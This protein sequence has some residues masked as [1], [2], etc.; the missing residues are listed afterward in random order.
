[1]SISYQALAQKKAVYYGLYGAG[2]VLLL[3]AG[4]LWWSK[5]SVEPQRVF[6]NMLQNSLATTG[7]ATQVHQENQGTT[8]D[9]T[10]QYAAGSTNQAQAV[11]VIKQGSMYVKT[12][13]RGDT[14][15]TY[16]QY[17]KISA[18]QKQDSNRLKNIV[19]VW[20]KSDGSGQDSTPLLSQAVLGVGLPV[21]VVPVP[22]ANV[23]RNDRDSLLRQM[24]ETGLYQVAYGKVKKSHTDGRLLYTYE[25]TMQPIIYLNIMK[26]FAKTV[27]LRDLETVD[28]NSYSGAEPVT[29]T[30][31]VDA[32]AGQLL[33]V[34]T[35]SGYA[36]DYTSYGVVPS[37]KMPT[38]TI[39]SSE[40][41]KRLSALQ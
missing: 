6:W 5:V 35:A 7:V 37:V 32:H 16:T 8:I 40:L 30:M 29:M 4:W 15:N 3:L 23:S 9:Q 1:M 33:Q 13:L 10:V 34:K 31:T 39:P 25:V 18:G 22:I 12:E 19:G 36:Q 14:Q 26:N 28:A 11:T 2:V 17:V 38:K 20:A 21:G 27:G 24:R 41:A